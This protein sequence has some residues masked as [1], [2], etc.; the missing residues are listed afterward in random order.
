MS[1]PIIRDPNAPPRHRGPSAPQ[2]GSLAWHEAKLAAIP[3]WRA[4][5][6]WQQHIATETQRGRCLAAVEGIRRRLLGETRWQA[7]VR[8]IR[9]IFG[10]GG[11]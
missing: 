9:S 10:R 4:L 8:R 6:W 11:P 5:R 2:P 1:D 3:R 7:I